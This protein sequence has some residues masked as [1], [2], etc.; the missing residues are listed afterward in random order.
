MAIWQLLA[1]EAHSSDCS[2]QHLLLKQS[3]KVV[4][5]IV[6]QIWYVIMHVLRQNVVGLLTQ[7]L[8]TLVNYC[9]ASPSIGKYVEIILK[10]K[11]FQLLI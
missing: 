10:G 7:Q 4:N 3:T 2:V 6:M 8:H 5:P 9:S 11:T 1:A